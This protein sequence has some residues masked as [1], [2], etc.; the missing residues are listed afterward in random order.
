MIHLVSQ[1]V[2]GRGLTIVGSV[3]HGSYL[4]S[5]VDVDEAKEVSSFSTSEIKIFSGKSF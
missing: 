4:S 3:M 1:F 5:T 2:L